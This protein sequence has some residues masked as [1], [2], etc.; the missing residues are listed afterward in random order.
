MTP[1]EAIA[2]QVFR[3]PLTK[4]LFYALFRWGWLAIL[5][6]AF[7]ITGCSVDNR[8]EWSQSDELQA[9][10][11]EEAAKASREFAGRAVCG[12]GAVHEWIGDKEITCHPKRGRSYQVVRSEP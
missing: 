1:Q 7:L 11:Q 4:R 3:K 12:P 6:L 2:I 10:Q 5:L 9:I 8:A